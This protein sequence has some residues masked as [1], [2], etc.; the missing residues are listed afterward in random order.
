MI[1][2]AIVED[3]KDDAKQFKEYIKQYQ[4][5]NSVFF[6]IK[7]FSSGIA[8]L[9]EYHSEYDIVFMDIDLP[10]LDGLEVSHKL[11]ERDNKVVLIFLTNLA[12]YAIKVIQLMLLIL[13]ANQ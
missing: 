7:T 9:E 5:E 8:F 2:I 11:R 13:F 4:T 12:K 3:T 10:G 1:K 6:E